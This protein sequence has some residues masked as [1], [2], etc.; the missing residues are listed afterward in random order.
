MELQM[1]IEKVWNF[2][3]AKGVFQNYT[4]TLDF[5]VQEY[6]ENEM[7]RYV[8]DIFEGARNLPEGVVVLT[9]LRDP[10]AEMDDCYIIFD[11]NN[12]WSLFINGE[13][14]VEKLRNN[15][16]DNKYLKQVLKNFLENKIKEHKTQIIA[17]ESFL[18]ENY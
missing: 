2:K 17:I 14:V 4:M 3:E 7:P 15:N 18:K 11:K 8:E 13:I 9:F 5:N 12:A 1:W 10:L 16:P 6:E